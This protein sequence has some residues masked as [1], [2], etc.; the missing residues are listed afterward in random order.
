MDMI[1]ILC[2]IAISLSIFAIVFFIFNYVKIVYCC[3][4]TDDDEHYVTQCGANI[5]T[6]TE[7]GSWH[8]C[9]NCGRPIKVKDVETLP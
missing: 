8:R 1:I 4:E 7:I 3:W 6:L 9:G 5:K 2:L